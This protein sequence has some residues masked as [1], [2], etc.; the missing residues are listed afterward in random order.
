MKKLKVSLEDPQSAVL[1]NSYEQDDGAGRKT[2]MCLWNHPGH[3][4]TGMINRCNKVVDTCETVRA[5]H[6]CIKFSNKFLQ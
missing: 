3:D 1:K 6:D 4:L 2:K 5:F